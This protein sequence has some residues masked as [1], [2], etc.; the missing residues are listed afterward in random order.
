[1]IERDDE[2]NEFYLKFILQLLEMTIHYSNFG[3]LKKEMRSITTIVGIIILVISTI[4][5]GW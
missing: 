2:K 5:L 4:N 3:S 1:M